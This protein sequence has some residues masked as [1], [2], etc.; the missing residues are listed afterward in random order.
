[1][2][3]A[4]KNEVANRAVKLVDTRKQS[5]EERALHLVLLLM[6]V[7]CVFVAVSALF[8]IL[9]ANSRIHD[10]ASEVS[11][12]VTEDGITAEIKRAGQCFIDRL[13]A[14]CKSL[15]EASTVSFLIAVLSAGVIA[16]AVSLVNRGHEELSGMKSKIDVLSAETRKNVHTAGEKVEELKA[17]TRAAKESVER[18]EKEA[19]TAL[20]RF[21]ES[22][23][24]DWEVTN[25]LSKAQQN[26]R[27]L[28]RSKDTKTFES[29]IP[30]LRDNLNYVSKGLSAAKEKVIKIA[31]PTCQDF[32]NE[33]LDIKMDLESVPKRFKNSVKDLIRRCDKII[34]LLGKLA[35]NNNQ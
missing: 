8:W 6:V 30:D 28:R 17:K 9:D 13:E 22:V 32:R 18:T 23:A 2:K 29:L 25:C 14:Y 27:K 3:K 33:A 21:F 24:I 11:E 12:Y 16:F 20:D 34:E 5:W 7:T 10:L 4:D 31:P 19:R 1:V 35:P 26:S 15:M